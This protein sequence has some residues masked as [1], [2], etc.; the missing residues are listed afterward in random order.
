MLAGDDKN[1]K[2]IKKRFSK[3]KKNIKI[4]KKD[5]KKEKLA[6][7][8][9]FHHILPNIFVGRSRNYKTMEI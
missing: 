4:K 1:V 5:L 6:P 9:L 3:K 8:L 2:N 7:G